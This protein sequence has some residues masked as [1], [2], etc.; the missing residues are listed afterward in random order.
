MDPGASDATAVIDQSL[1]AILKAA[2]KMRDCL[3]VTGDPSFPPDAESLISD[4]SRKLV[5][6]K[7]Q[8]ENL[9]DAFSK[10]KSEVC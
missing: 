3:E 6:M 10:T 1:E 5:K 9:V 7:M 4:S 8:M 2:K